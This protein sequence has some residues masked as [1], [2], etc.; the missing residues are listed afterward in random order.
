MVRGAQPDVLRDRREHGGSFG[1]ADGPG[2][3]RVPVHL[4]IN[5]GM[6]R[7]GVR[8]SGAVSLA[9]RIS[10]QNPRT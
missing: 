9:Q 7:Y 1:G 6:N 3:P 4:K 10:N 2:G 5:T 8:W